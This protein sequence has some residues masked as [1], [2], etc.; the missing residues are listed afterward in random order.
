MAVPPTVYLHVLF[1][2]HTRTRTLTRLVGPYTRPL[3]ARQ[4]INVR[5]YGCKHRCSLYCRYVA[6]LPSTSIIIVIPLAGR[7][8]IH[9][10]CQIH[11]TTEN[12][13]GI[14]RRG[15]GNNGGIESERERE[16]GVLASGRPI[17]PTRDGVRRCRFS[18]L[19]LLLL[20]SCIV[21]L[22]RLIAR[23]QQFPPPPQ[24][25]SFF[26]FF[27]P[28]S[29]SDNLAHGIVPFFLPPFLPISSAD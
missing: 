20:A 12:F 28:L 24:F 11:A 19:L 14:V 26:L 23:N 21:P 2:T 4:P 9:C 1:S 16:R 27:P 6:V 7:N 5:A 29:L 10:S 15:K 3:Y 8:V 22:F 13:H 17:I 18:L 25:F